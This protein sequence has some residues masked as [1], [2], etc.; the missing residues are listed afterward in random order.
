MSRILL[1]LLALL[2]LACT[3][4][5]DTSGLPSIDGF[6]SWLSHE[7]RGDVPAH[8]D[9]VRITYAN[10]IAT[11]YTGGGE[12]AL[13]SV[14][15]KEIFDDTGTDLKYHAVMRRLEEAPSGGELEG[16][17]AGPGGWL[18]TRFDELGDAEIQGLTC[19]S[20]CHSQAPFAGTWLD[21][22]RLF[23]EL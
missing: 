15:V 12:Y 14:L 13:G 20:N 7:T 8:S 3:T 21:Y 9:G 6:D 22:G 5:V 19:W 11:G 17:G 16:A 10:D 4:E 2:P 1:P 23:D 18:F